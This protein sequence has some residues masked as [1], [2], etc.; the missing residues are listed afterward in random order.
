M[1]SIRFLM[2]SC[3]L[4]LTLLSPAAAG[5]TDNCH[6]FRDR[7]YDPAHRFV[8]DDYL[9]TTS[10]NS[11]IAATLSVSKRQIVMMK[12]KGG[13]DPNELLIALYIADKA[14]A[15]LDALLS[16]RDN[17]GNWQDILN[18]PSLQQNTG[19][20]PVFAKITAGTGDYDITS[21]ITDAM[22]SMYYHAKPELISTLRSE[23]FSNKELGLIFA[24]NKQ[25]TTSVKEIVGMARQK[26]MSWSE[27]A[28]HF[29]LTPAGVGKTILGNQT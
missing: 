26:K 16:I 22:I 3:L 5:Q 23:D 24:L 1:K 29:N 15:P 27:I 12:M 9:L 25:A 11:L 10:F 2:L 14:Q 6:C 19:T 20:D 28:H 8:A 21:L 7:S 17:G 4:I 13:V 18:S